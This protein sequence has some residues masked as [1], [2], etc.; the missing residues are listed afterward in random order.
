MVTHE[1]AA[2]DIADRVLTLRDGRLVRVIRDALAA[3]RARR[4]RTLLAALGVLAA[5]LVVG[6]ATTVGYSLATGLR[7]LGRA[8]RPARRDRPLHARSRARRSTSAS[9]RCRTSRR[10]RTASSGSTA[11]LVV[12]GAPDR[13]RARSRRVLGG[14]RGYTIVD[15]RDL[16]DG[17][18][19]RSRD[20]ARPRARV[21]HAASATRMGVDAL[22]ARCGSSGSRSRPTTSPTRWPAPR[23]ST[24]PAGVVER[25]GRRDQPNVA[26]LWLNDP[27]KADVTLTQARA[28]DVRA[29]EAAVHHPHGR[30]DP[31][32]ARPRGS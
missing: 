25:F 26:L 32:L 22:R 30:G 23:A 4:G 2:A 5:S 19:R 3:L 8:G 13:A 29:R 20:R 9:P 17:A 27:S 31:A 18:H 1:T 10:A 11:R 21:G 28:V 7:S 16:R 15:G 14:R 12:P 24:S 6:T